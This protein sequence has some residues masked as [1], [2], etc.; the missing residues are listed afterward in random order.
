MGEKTLTRTRHS[1]KYALCLKFRGKALTWQRAASFR[2]LTLGS[3]ESVAVLLFVREQHIGAR[4]R[5]RRALV[6]VD[7]AATILTYHLPHCKAQMRSPRL[8]ELPHGDRWIRRRRTT[9]V[10]PEGRGVR[11]LEDIEIRRVCNC[12]IT[13]RTLRLPRGGE[14]THFESI[15]EALPLRSD[16]H[17]LIDTEQVVLLLGPTDSGSGRRL[18]KC[19]ATGCWGAQCTAHLQR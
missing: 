10:H 5:V 7:R 4:N 9:V 1:S 2:H 13:P 17:R 16:C 11:G 6:W 12:V 18:H 8:L 3:N 15:G 14:V 19:P